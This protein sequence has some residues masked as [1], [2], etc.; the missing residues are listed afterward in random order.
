MTVCIGT[1][2]WRE[3]AII[4]VADKALTVRGSGLS[5]QAET[6]V[7]KIMPISTSG[8]YVMWAGT[9][10][11]ATDVVSRVALALKQ[12][13]SEADSWQSMMDRVKE[14]Y[15]QCRELSVV[16][17][18]LTPHL[19]TKDLLVARPA[20]LLP[21]EKDHYMGLI[22]KLDEYEVDCS[23]LVCGF[24]KNDKPHIF[25]FHDPGVYQNHDETGYW[26]I[27]IGTQTAL[28][29]LLEMETLKDDDLVKALYGAF[30]AKARAEIMQGVGYG[31][32]AEILSVRKPQSI[33][34]PR[35][36]IDLIDDAYMAF[37]GSPFDTEVK[38]S[39]KD[40]H[41]KIGKFMQQKVDHSV[42]IPAVHYFKQKPKPSKGGG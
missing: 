11:F 28:A 7:K 24:D 25:S 34:V 41:I 2:A 39:P 4:M 5:M 36:I 35:K 22:D 13:P 29:R 6:G 37:P 17:N 40:W 16:E 27:G 3:K 12:Y 38:R 26:A 31:W 10:T 21:L 42:K 18:I 14:A 9:A 20:T 32:D 8:W 15:Q 23:L 33:Q 1:I 30:D 19:L